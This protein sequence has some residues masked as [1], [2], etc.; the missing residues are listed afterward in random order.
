[1]F[2]FTKSKTAYADCDRLPATLPAAARRER[3][4]ISAFGGLDMGKGTGWGISEMYNLSPRRAPA[5]S[6]RPARELLLPSPAEGDPHGMALLGDDLYFARGTRLFRIPQVMNFAS[7]PAVAEVGALSDTDKSMAVFGDCLLIYPDKVYV[8]ADDRQLHPMELDTGIIGGLSFEGTGISMPTGRLWETAGFREGD[9]VYVKDFSGDTSDPS[10][11]YLIQ[12]IVGSTAY[13][14]AVFPE[15]IQGSARLLRRVP[16]LQAV[17]VCGNRLYGYAGRYIY[18]GEEGTPFA[19]QSKK[20]DRER[21]L[22]LAGNT[23]GPFT[24]CASC[25]DEA[26]FFKQGSVS[27][28]IGISAGAPIL[29]EIHAVGIPSAF[30]HTLCEMNG[31]LCYH[32]F[33][34]VY[35]YSQTKRRPERIAR[36]CHGTPLT[37]HAVA[38]DEGY[39]VSITGESADGEVFAA[40]CL[41]TSDTQAWYTE[42]DTAMTDGV[43]LDGYLC[44]VDP[45]GNFWLSRTDGRRAGCAADANREKTPLSSFVSFLPDYACQPQTYRPANL[46]LRLT[47]AG[48]GALSVLCSFADGH[49][50]LD[51]EVPLARQN[52]QEK[53]NIREIACVSGKM[54]DRLV[55]IPLP[56]RRCNYV[57]FALEMVGDWVVHEMIFEYDLSGQ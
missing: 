22:T 17:T 26:V 23:D 30:S 56:P 34:G 1:M 51:A 21:F 37:G 41:Y 24:A 9:A 27:R 8:S 31:D 5:L 55:R 35:R 28:V 50:N 36:I 4:R 14:N 46:Y 47:S 25:G 7:A 53:E 13:V 29:S 2:A 11:K 18:I 33:D 48:A 49:A 39:C 32:G 10:G 45:A 54:T 16:D 20:G 40:R 38:Y 3:V 57:A 44:S 15:E 19:W 43:S 12:K 52:R 42:D 6:T